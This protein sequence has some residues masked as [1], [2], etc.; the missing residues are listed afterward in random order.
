MKTNIKGILITRPTQELVIMRGIPG[1]GKS[2]M[3]KSLVRK[4]RIHS[5]DDVIESQGDY[6]KFF[7][8][9][10]ESKD[11]SP[12]A[13]AHSTNY[14]NIVKSISEGISPVIVD[15][16]NIKANE[17]KQIVVKALEMGLNENKINIVDM[18][19]NGLTAE[20]LADRN[21]HGVP[22]DKIKSMIE[23]YKSVGNLTI[24]KI[25]ESKDMYP[26][27][28]V[29]Y[30]CVLLEKASQ[31]VLFHNLEKMI[32]E[33]WVRFGHHMTICMGPL[34]DKSLLGTEQ[35]LAVTKVGISD[36]A[37]AVAVSVQSDI[38]T[39]NEISHVTVAINPDGGKP[40]M[41]NDITN[42]QD[43]RIFILL[44]KVTEIKKGS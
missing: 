4:G 31:N 21:T 12:L 29:L 3:A 23:S 36:M 34:K 33:G 20:V 17:A 27:S 25:L 44:G 35:L 24:K 18:G 28:D 41:S 42:W 7:V 16:T 32:P 40:V 9:M 15:N 13:R 30:S 11:F 39:K 1:S 14:K 26:Q 5:T 43:V 2:T 10:K 22:L 38:E 8:D 19:T 37:M 6:D